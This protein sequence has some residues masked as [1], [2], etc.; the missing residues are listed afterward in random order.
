MIFLM[1]GI[2]PVQNG[3]PFME[4]RRLVSVVM[5]IIIIIMIIVIIINF[6]S[7]AAARGGRSEFKR[8]PF[9]CCR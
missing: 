4:A 5:A 7:A 2:S 3:P 9:N 1:S 6:F 8:L